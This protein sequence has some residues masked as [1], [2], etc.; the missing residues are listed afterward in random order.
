[1]RVYVLLIVF[2][3]A[4]C[5]EVSAPAQVSP[6]PLP[7]PVLPIADT[8]ARGAPPSGAESA[9]VGYVVVDATGARLLDGLSFSAGATPQPLSGAAAQIWLD[10]DAVGALTNALR[11]AGDIR[12][13]AVLARGHLEGPA[14]YGPG[15]AYR[16][17]LSSA[18]LRPLAP[19]DT[20][21][22]ALLSNSATYDGQLVRVAGAL[23]TR[24]DSALLVDHVG[25]G[26]LPEAGARQL[27][28]PGP[29][30]D[31]ALLARLRRA[32]AGSVRFGPVQVEGFWQNGALIPLALFPIS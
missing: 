7:A 8:L 28:L 1:M 32:P 22:A 11:T 17:R 20:T 2:L 23:L 4:A 26:G 5:S 21:I 18:Q 31:T 3:L 19:Q 10:A 15:G 13:A 24:A 27:K 29:L 12:Y 16:Y 6:T 25:S 30:R 14:A 9:T